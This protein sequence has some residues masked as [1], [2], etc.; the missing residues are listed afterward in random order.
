MYQIMLANTLGDAFDLQASQRLNSV[1]VSCD[2]VALTYREL[3][4]ESDRLACLLR[5]LGAGPETRVG[6]V[7]A[8][9]TQMVVAMLAIVKAGAAYVPLDFSHPEERLHSLLDDAGCDVVVASS[10]VQL[11]NK[12]RNIIH[13]DGDWRT[14]TSRPTPSPDRKS[15]PTISLT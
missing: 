6:H 3:S 9:S 2:G 10:T 15:S 5:S 12:V 14:G 4:E 11:P 7:V 8:R 1:A 13:V